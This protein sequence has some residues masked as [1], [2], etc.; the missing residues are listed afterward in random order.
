M[1]AASVLVLLLLVAPS[2][3]CFECLQS[4]GVCAR[5]Q[6]ATVGGEYIHRVFMHLR[7]RRLTSCS[8]EAH[9]LWIRWCE[10]GLLCED[11]A[12]S[13]IHR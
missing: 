1:P 10:A 11:A 7:L 9:Q 2:V 3:S 5:G 4:G 12:S 13:F 8:A 6:T